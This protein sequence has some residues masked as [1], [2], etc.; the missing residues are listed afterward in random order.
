ML[1]RSG[2]RVT[3]ERG[4]LHC[5]CQL[6]SDRGRMGRWELQGGEALTPESL[7]SL[8]PAKESPST[9]NLC[10]EPCVL[11]ILREQW[12]GLKAWLAKP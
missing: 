7:Q 2:R 4:M 10:C 5:G 11:F 12:T 9:V 6:L 3:A 8:S 1:V